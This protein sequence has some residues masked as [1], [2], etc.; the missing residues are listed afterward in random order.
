MRRGYAKNPKATAATI[1]PDGWLRT[2][3]VAVADA[4][5]YLQIT[6]RIKELAINDKVTGD[7]QETPSVFVYNGNGA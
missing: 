7:L 1:T 3:D 2:G 6:D 5:G 4:G